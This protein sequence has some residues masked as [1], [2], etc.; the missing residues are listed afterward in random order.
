MSKYK[1]EIINDYLN[2]LLDSKTSKQI[3]ELIK[4]D[5]TARSIA[6]GILL[7][8]KEFRGDEKAVEA[9]LEKLGQ[10]QLKLISKETQSKSITKTVWFRVAAALLL[11]VATAAILRLLVST[12]DFN[13]IVSK[14]LAQAYPVSN[15]VRSDGIESSKERGYQLYSEGNY[16]SA[17]EYFEKAI[18]ADNSEASIVF[19]NGLCNLY[20]GNYERANSVLASD[21]IAESR[22]VQQAQWYRALALLKS[23]QKAKAIEILRIITGN[24]RHFKYEVAVQLMKDLE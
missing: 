3:G 1:Y 18:A 11:L 17:S 16:E 22:Y 10:K 19:Y 15:L 2:G 14:E 6:H 23:N 20:T 24:E 21:A 5:E 8:D 7:L 13:T 12:P 9:Y 4:T